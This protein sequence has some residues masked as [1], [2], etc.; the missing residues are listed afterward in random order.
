MRPRDIAMIVALLGCL[1]LAGCARY[2]WS[3][4]DTTAE[5]LARDQ[6]DCDAQARD[7]ARQY[8]VN[9]PR[10]GPWWR[11]PFD[12][13]TRP[14]LMTQVDIEQQIF[15]QCMQYKGYRLVKLPKDT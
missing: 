4:P 13:W 15:A 2:A 10:W 12:S 6:I 9:R 1:A 8:W 14:D 5:V 7:Q 3:K 11:D